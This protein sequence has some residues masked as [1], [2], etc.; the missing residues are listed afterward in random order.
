MVSGNSNVPHKSCCDCGCSVIILYHQTQ[1]RVPFPRICQRFFLLTWFFVCINIFFTSFH[2]YIFLNVSWS[3]SDLE[4]QHWYLF[5]WYQSTVFYSLLFLTPFAF[6]TNNSLSYIFHHRHAIPGSTGAT[7][8]GEASRDKKTPS[9]TTTGTIFQAR[10]ASVLGRTTRYNYIHAYNTAAVDSR[11]PM[12]FRSGK[13]FDILYKFET[14]SK[15]SLANPAHCACLEQDPD[16]KIHHLHITSLVFTEPL[17]VH[18]REKEN[19]Y[20]IQHVSFCTIPKER[21]ELTRRQKGSKCF[22]WFVIWGY[23]GARV[24]SSLRI[25]GKVWRWW[26]WWLGNTWEVKKERIRW[27]EGSV[28]NMLLD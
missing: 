5:A 13:S 23:L 22:L 18:H 2:P 10:P 7:N 12:S 16:M 21:T 3:S 19:S 25:F 20:R 28:C 26:W 14:N 8:T 11:L 1:S 6:I 27:D 24:A 4:K 9:G 17:T 15:P